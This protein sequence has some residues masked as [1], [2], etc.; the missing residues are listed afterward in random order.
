MIRR[1]YLYRPITDAEA[2]A[3]GKW[4]EALGDD[5]LTISYRPSPVPMRILMFDAVNE[6][7]KRRRDKV[8]LLP[9]PEDH[10][11]DALRDAMASGDVVF[12]VYTGREDNRS[13]EW[14]GTDAI[15]T[16]A[17]PEGEAVA[18]FARS[19]GGVSPGIAAQ[20]YWRAGTWNAW[21][22][23]VRQ[24]HESV[25]LLFFKHRPPHMRVHEELVMAFA[26]DL[27]DS[28]PG[29]SVVAAR[30]SAA[31]PESFRLQFGG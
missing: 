30:P 29:G 26:L 21:T 4:A 7:G 18:F 15:F 2:R 10:A 17:F 6:K 3:A 28:V 13:M 19:S 23:E 31:G 12:N 14:S 1:L 9:A 25:R 5:G 27:L 11:A 8:R 22:T 20:C 16:V 24:I